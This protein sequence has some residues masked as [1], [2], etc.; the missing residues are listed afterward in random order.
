MDGFRKV[1]PP[2]DRIRFDGGMNS[3]YEKWR[4]E[5]NQSPDCQNVRFTSGGVRTR[6]GTTRLGTATLGTLAVGDGIYTRHTDTGAETMVVFAGGLMKYWSGSTFTTIPSAQSVWTAGVRVG[7]AEQEN[8]MFIGNGGVI[9]YKYNE[10]FTRHGVYPPTSTP[11]VTSQATGSLTGGYRY[12][13]TNVNSAS[14][15]SDVG[16]TNATF[17][18]ASATLRVT[19]QTFAASYGVNARNIYRTA[20]SGSVF[21]FV[22]TVA[23]NTSTTYDDNLADASLGVDAPTDNGVP[24]KYNVIKY[25][26]GRLFMNDADNPN[27]LWFSDIDSPYTVS[28]TN[29]IKIG[30]ATSDL[31][32]CIDVFEN[33]I[34]V[35]CDNSQFIIYMPDTDETNWVQVRV[36]SPFGSKSPYGSFRFRDKLM[37]PAVENGQFVGFAPMSG[38]GV[39]PNT[40]FLSVNSLQSLLISN[41]IQP[42]L[43]DI[44]EAY[45]GN[46]SATVFQSLGY[47]T[48]TSGNAQTTNNKVWVFDFENDTEG[49]RNQYA[50]SPDTGVAA[51]QFTIYSNKLYFVTSTAPCYVNEYETTTFNDNGT[52]IDSYFWTKE[53]S[54]DNDSNIGIHKDFRYIKLLVE[55]S[56]SYFMNL[57]VRVDSDSGSGNTKQ[58]DLTSGGSLWGTF[59]WGTDLWDAGKAKEDKKIFLDGTRGE[60][61]Q[62][63]FS[64]RNIVNQKFEVEGLRFYF[65][66]R[67]FR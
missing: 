67:G 34:L 21:K 30:D 43:F 20:T 11:V 24:P 16:P 32:R 6:G 29:F 33:N 65:N 53:F 40:T 56:G 10:T 14:V 12:K 47:I 4:I 39:A 37:I 7:A 55:L 59:V 9:P 18:A 28:S 13:I 27:F 57:G 38:S 64:N 22:A 51:A 8:Y 54:A 52:A 26:Q 23:N 50:W 3:K 25:H 62:F 44:Q 17:A 63:K 60:R 61:I 5:D 42:N 58:I 45:T 46:I 48:V 15:E 35:S 2:T 41:P 49:G 1:Y 66:F 36:Q 31:I 19:I